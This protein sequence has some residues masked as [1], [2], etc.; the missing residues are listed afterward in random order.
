MIYFCCDQRRRND[1]VGSTRNGIDYL[2]VLDHEIA[3]SDPA[4]RQKKLILHFI[5]NLAA[6]ALDKSNI[7]I[8]GG[9]RTPGIVAES[10]VV[11]AQDA[12]L[13]NIDLSQYGDFSIYTLRLVQNGQ[14]LMP[15]AIIDP[16]FAA[17]DFSFKVDCPSDFDCQPRCDCP[18]APPDEPEIDYLAKDYSSFR[19]LMLDRMAALMPQWRERNPADLGVTLV[20]LLAYVGDHLSYQQDAVATEAYLGTARRRVS[21]RRHAKLVDYHMHEGCNARAWVQMRLKEGATATIAPGGTQ[22]FTRIPGQPTV[23]PDDPQLR[24]QAQAVFEPMETVGLFADH[25][26][27]ELYTWSDQRCCLPKGATDATLKGFH[28]DLKPGHVVV[29]EEV[30]NPNTGQSEDA[31][32]KHRW[33]VRLTAV[34]AHDEN[35]QP[36]RDLLTQQQITQIAWAEADALAYPFCVSAQTDKAHGARFIDNVT[37]VRGNIVLADHGA[38]IVGEELGSVGPALPVPPSSTGC[39]RCEPPDIEPIAPRFQPTIAK[40]PLTFAA[41]HDQYGAANAAMV[42][43]ERAAAPAITLTGLYKGDST[44]WQ[45]RPDLLQSSGTDSHFVVEIES[46]GQTSLRFGDDTLGQRPKSTT[47]FTAQYR[48][49]NGAAGNVGAEAL[50]HLRTGNALLAAATS[51]I[52]NP[53]AAQGG[54]EPES[55]EQVRAY[56]PAAYRTQKRAVT[57]ADYAAVAGRHPG[58]QRAMATFRWTG[59][60]HT[61]FITV[62]RQDGKV[63]D[64]IF[65][66]SVRKFVEPF[67]MAGHDVEVEGPL[68][69]S[70]EID[71]DV[72]ADPAYFRADVKRELLELFSTRK[73]ANDRRGLFHPDNFTFGQTVYL[74]PLIAAAQAV[75]G[76]TSVQISKFQRQ[77]KPDNKPLAQ[78]ILELGRL[79]IARCDNDRNFPEHGVFNLNVGGG[80]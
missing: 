51:E 6:G 75:Q 63:V 48:V 18:A 38:T 25:N 36:L 28:P 62:D 23:L 71:M 39:E 73:F 41:P 59:S 17:V 9:E 52:R 33:A 35:N 37:V 40:Q 8:E 10:V 26:Q 44:P 19:R 11:D 22:F 5:N 43:K 47:S 67:R 61:V 64:A 15:P 74:S 70:L 50:A 60:W 46:D 66:A 24:A 72:C 29:F 7:L 68:P 69:V 42:W 45:P 1:L 80:K 76:V 12:T 20:E 27:F 79:E 3:Q 2:E 53:L 49:G 34:Q 4:H 77:G 57:E 58:V 56:A 32:P 55:M 21:V 30:L 31:D 54:V 13:L 78:G 65:E 16:M 14:N